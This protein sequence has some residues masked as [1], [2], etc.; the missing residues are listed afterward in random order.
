MTDAP[1]TTTQIKVVT[2]KH[3]ILSSSFLS[4][5]N[6]TTHKP[7]TTNR[8]DKLQCPFT[9]ATKFH[10]GRTFLPGR[11]LPQL[12]FPPWPVPCSLG[13]YSLRPLPWGLNHTWQV[14]TVPF[15]WLSILDPSLSI[16]H[17][18]P[19]SLRFFFTCLFLA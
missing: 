13:V 19:P 3:W 17:P 7:Q 12:H 16:L 11:H 9:I 18:T 10:T 6:R 4:L 8:K 14:T 5:N 2:D 15:K 1:G